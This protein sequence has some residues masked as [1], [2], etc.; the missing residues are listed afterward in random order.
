MLAHAHY[1][2]RLSACLWSASSYSGN[3]P[4]DENRFLV[5]ESLITNAEVEKAMISDLSIVCSK[6][7]EVKLLRFFFCLFE[8]VLYVPVNSNGHAGTLPPF[9]GTK[10]RFINITT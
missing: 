9:H 8:L 7:S 4:Q 2:L 1:V 5:F 6:F 3:T 10:M